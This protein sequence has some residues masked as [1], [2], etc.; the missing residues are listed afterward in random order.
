MTLC[1]L[2]IVALAIAGM[3]VFQSAKRP[4]SLLLEAGIAD[5]PSSLTTSRPALLEKI[6]LSSIRQDLVPQAPPVQTEQAVPVPAP[7]PP[8]PP[9]LP[10]QV[11]IVATFTTSAGPSSAFVRYNDSKPLSIWLPGAKEGIYT[12]M[13]IGD[14]W[15]ALE[16]QGNRHVLRVERESQ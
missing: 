15:V 2:G 3:N 8:P 13:E 11:E 16:G 5:T 14:G 12:V 7:H 6:A 1:L 9:S 4:A 10:P